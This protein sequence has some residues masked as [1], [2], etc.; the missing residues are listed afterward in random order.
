[1][2][3]LRNNALS[4]V[5]FGMFGIMLVGHSLSG[6]IEHNNNLAEH[7][8]PSLGYFEYLSSGAFV[9]SVFENWESE[10]LQMAAYVLLTIWL[11]QNGSPESKKLGVK[12]PEDEDPA[13]HKND[14]NAPWPVRKGGFILAIYKH[15]LSIALLSLFVTSFCLHAAGG[16]ADMNEQLRDKGKPQITLCDYM[17]SSKFWFESF[18][19]WQSE[20]L[21]VGVLVVL[22]IFLRQIGSPESKPVAASR[23]YTGHG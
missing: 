19:N 14:P 9:E 23:E 18:Q 16:E 5:M 13:L 3:F 8:K 4:I 10:F 21:S 7:G 2:K 22:Q 12:E 1:M 6:H 17:T 20:F 11:R 15:S